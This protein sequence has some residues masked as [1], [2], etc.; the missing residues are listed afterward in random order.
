[1]ERWNI[2]NTLTERSNNAAI[3]FLVSITKSRQAGRSSGG[4]SDLPS[5]RD[6]LV[7]FEYVSVDFGRDA[8]GKDRSVHLRPYMV[9]I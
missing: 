8:A 7:E 4:K 3:M 5:P 2:N 6:F 9:A 1:M